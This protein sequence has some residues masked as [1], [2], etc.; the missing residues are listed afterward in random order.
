[1]AHILDR[2]DGL[3]DTRGLDGKCVGSCLKKSLL[4]ARIFG[5]REL[6]TDCFLAKKGACDSTEGH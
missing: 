1:M 5:Q 2:V 4:E 6:A 3:Q